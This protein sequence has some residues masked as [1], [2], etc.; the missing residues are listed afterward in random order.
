MKY[1]FYCARADD[2][3]RI[4]RYFQKLGEFCIWQQ[5]TTHAHCEQ[6]IA[7]SN[8]ITMSHQ[9]LVEVRVTGEAKFPFLSGNSHGKCH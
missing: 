3:T 2:A 4:S 8:Y 1:F 7:G 6:N 9:L 5:N